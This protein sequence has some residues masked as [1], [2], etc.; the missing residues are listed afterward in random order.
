MRALGEQSLLFFSHH[1]RRR[2]AVCP[3]PGGLFCSEHSQDAGLLQE[4]SHVQV[5]LRQPRRSQ[6]QCDWGSVSWKRARNLIHL[7]SQD[8]KEATLTGQQRRTLLRI[9]PKWLDT[10][11]RLAACLHPEGCDRKL[12][13]ALYF[14]AQEH[15][16]Q[17]LRFA[18]CWNL[19]LQL[20]S[21]LSAWNTGHD[22]K[23][24][25]RQRGR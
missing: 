15:R 14:A 17:T 20:Q 25:H 3:L 1:N 16:E 13:P 24:E 6:Q 21:H 18:R 2:Y 9:R 4:E 19:F 11:S 8:G 10:G 5:W 23:T 7:E 22:I 12:Q